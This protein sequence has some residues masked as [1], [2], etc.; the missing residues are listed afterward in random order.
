MEEAQTKPKAILA[1]SSGK[2]SAYA[3]HV[4]RASG[5]FEIGALLTTVTEDYARVSMH[6]VR[7]EILDLQAQRAGL[8]LIKVRIPAPCPNETYEAA[9]AAA[10][11]PLCDQGVSHVIFGDLFLEDLRVWREERLARMGLTG[12]FPLWGRDTARL[13][14]DMVADGLEARIVCLDPKRLNPCF[15]GHGFNEELLDKLP[16]DVDPCGENGEFHTL[17]TAGPMFS[18]AIR[19]ENGVVVEREGFVFAD[20]LVNHKANNP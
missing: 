17:T 1:W 4:A 18:H 3:L 14:R 11:G 7:E 20:V 9:M 10:L 2:D 6:G 5:E 19:A 15:A 12:V 8:P 16:G 13:A